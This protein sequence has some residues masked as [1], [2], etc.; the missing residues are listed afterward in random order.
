L[1]AHLRDEGRLRAAALTSLQT[2]H[3]ARNAVEAVV[4]IHVVVLSQRMAG[5]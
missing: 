5:S 1:L 2:L 3:A 4:V